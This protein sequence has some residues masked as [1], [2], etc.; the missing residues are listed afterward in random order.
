MNTSNID[1]LHTTK[2]SAS[3]LLKSS[4]RG[5]A[6]KYNVDNSVSRTLNPLTNR[7]QE[8][9]NPSMSLDDFVDV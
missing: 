2:K 3:K 4:S 7:G 8:Y 1:S 9:I 6:D 5:S